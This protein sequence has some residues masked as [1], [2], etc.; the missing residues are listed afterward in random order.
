[1]TIP[2]MEQ[3]LKLLL[4][5]ISM[6]VV[7]T[8]C[9]SIDAQIK[10]HKCQMVVVLDKTNSVNFTSRLPLL[11]SELARNFKLIYQNS[12]QDIQFARFKIVGKTRVFPD[13]DR[14]SKNCP[15][16]N[17]DSRS[18][19]LRFLNWQTEKKLWMIKELKQTMQLIKDS[20]N[21]NTTDIFGIFDGLQQVRQNGGPWDSITVLIFSDMVNTTHVINMKRDVNINNA[22]SKGKTICQSLLSKGQLTVGGAG[23][24]YLTIYTPDNMSQTAEVHLFWKGFFEQWGMHEDHYNFQ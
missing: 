9:G 22:F 4:K 17:S 15:D 7:I 19:Q 16:P 8:S 12:L 20:C 3:N 24:L 6:A 2:R 18:G 23:N 10:S 21:N 11:E 5:L 13:I 1:M 14:F